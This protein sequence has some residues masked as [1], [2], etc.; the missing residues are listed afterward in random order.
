MLFNSV[1]FLF[2]FVI[3][4]FLYYFVLK[5]KAKLQNVLLL[6]ASYV[7]YAWANWKILPLLAITTAGFYGLG[8]ALFDAKTDK[9]KQLFAVLGIIFGIGTLLYFKYFIFFISSFNDLFELVGLQTNWHTFKI[10]VPIG[11]SF[12]TFRLLSYI[13]DINRGKIEPTHDIIAF[14]A[15]VAFFPCIL[16]GPIDRPTTL[17]PQLQSKRIF[18]YS[19]AVDGMRQILW[20]LFKKI[21]IADSCVVFVNQIF[22]NYQDQSGSTLLLAAIFF[23][24]QLYADFSGYSDMAIGVAK[25]LGFRVTKNFDYP[26]FAQNIAEFWR[27]WHISLTSWL[28]DY[29]FMPLNIVLRNWGKWGMIV[30]IIVNFVI[31]GLWHGDNWTFVFWGFYNGLLFIPL[32]LSGAMFKKNKIETYSFGFPKPKT[33]FNIM[34]TFGLGIIGVVFFRSESI[35]QAFEYFGGMIHLDTLRTSY[36]III[37]KDAWMIWYILFMLVIEW[38]GRQNQHGL[39]QFGLKWKKWVRWLFYYILVI[40]I[41]AFSGNAQ[42][43]IYFQF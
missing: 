14:A 27:K 19:L 16:A 35:G 38:I 20:G 11:I 4:F 43:F 37:Q 18:D 28:T 25:L 15:Y 23:F 21:V 29:V 9:R 3:V 22:E 42:E 39:E 8:I 36:R 7:F 26:F 1:D 2:F 17:I 12:Y 40:L 13:I 41:S 10:I 34:L 33:L 5:E 32:I 31:C 24:F 6:V 30:A